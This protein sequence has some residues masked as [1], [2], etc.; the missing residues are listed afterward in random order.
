MCD[1]GPGYP[2]RG[3]E[4]VI[5]LN[6]RSHELMTQRQ[7]DLIV[8]VVEIVCLIVCVLK[9]KFWTVI[10]TILVLLLTRCLGQI[11]GGIAQHREISKVGSN[12]VRVEI[13]RDALKATQIK[14]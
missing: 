9:W 1:M 10:L 12:P 6:T 8:G 11:Y 2:S 13:L 7:V 3:A 5:F 14:Q 4:G